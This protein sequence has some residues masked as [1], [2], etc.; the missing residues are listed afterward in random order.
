MTDEVVCWIIDCIFGERSEKR[1][2]TGPNHTM[3]FTPILTAPHRTS[4]SATIC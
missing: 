2:T 3:F 4:V 1:A